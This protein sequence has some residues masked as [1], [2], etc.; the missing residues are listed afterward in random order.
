MSTTTATEVKRRTREQWGS[1][2]CGAIYG[3]GYSIGTREFFDSVEAHRYEVYAPW[4]REVMDFGGFDGR[5]LLEVG[6]GMGSDLL[7]FARGGARVTGLDY[8]PR[9]VE[10]SRQ[11]FALYDLTGVFTVGDAENP[12]F[13][14]RVL[15]RRVLE[16]RASPHAG[17]PA[18]DRPDPSRTQTRRC[19]EG[20]ALPPELHLLLDGDRVEARGSSRRARPLD[21][22]RD[23]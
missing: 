12:A 22:G 8:T 5:D 3:D 4:M 16:W 13:S 11:R 20:H 19:R 6:C 23:H 21:A 14:R 15:R 1:D 7:Q 9:S 18:V 2:P 17:R 10:I